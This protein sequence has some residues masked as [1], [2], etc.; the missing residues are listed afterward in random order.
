MFADL[1]LSSRKQ[2]Q[3]R[4]RLILSLLLVTFNP[5]FCFLRHHHGYSARDSSVI[6]IASHKSTIRSYVGVNCQITKKTFNNAVA[7]SYAEYSIDDTTSN[8]KNMN[9]DSEIKQEYIKLG[10]LQSAMT[11]V[12]VYYPYMFR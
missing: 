2:L 9:D 7:S 5:C 4:Y 1:S 6:Q 3:Q 10:K 11:K 12:S 8:K